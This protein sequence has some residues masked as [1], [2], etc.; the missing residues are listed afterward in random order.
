MRPEPTP[1]A[2]PAER[3]IGHSDGLPVLEP[4]KGAALTEDDVARLRDLLQR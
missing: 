4:V 2:R 3:P 1:P